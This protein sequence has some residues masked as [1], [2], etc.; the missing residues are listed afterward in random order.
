[1]R[2]MASPRWDGEYGVL[3]SQWSF[4]VS[5]RSRSHAPLELS[6]KI[7]SDR[8]A[9]LEMELFY[10]AHVRRVLDC[11]WAPLL[12]RMRKRMNGL[13]RLV[14]EEAHRGAAVLAMTRH[15]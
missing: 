7:T 4:D 9:I 3:Y 11:V 6:G 1:M 14:C 15:F 2:V 5:V 12:P 10:F 13:S 8:G